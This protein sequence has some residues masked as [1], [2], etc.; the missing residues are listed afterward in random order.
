M[1]VPDEHEV[2]EPASAKK[3]D[4]HFH[5]RLSDE[6]YRFL[7][8]AARQRDQSMADVVRQLIRR[9]RLASSAPRPAPQRSATR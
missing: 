2:R 4:R 5:L 8:E 9:L 3:K 7:E 6:D 1:R